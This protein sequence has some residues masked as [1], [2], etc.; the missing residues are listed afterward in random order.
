MVVVVVGLFAIGLTALGCFWVVRAVRL[1]AARRLT[2]WGMLVYLLLRA[3]LPAVI[4]SAALLVALP[5]FAP[6]DGGLRRSQKADLHNWGLAI[7]IYAEAHEGA[8]PP[9]L[10]TLFQQGFAHQ[11]FAHGPGFSFWPGQEVVYVQ[12]RAD[13]PDD[14]VMAYY[15]PAGKGGTYVLFK[16][17]IPDWAP[18]DEEGNLINPRSEE[19]IPTAG[20][21]QK[22]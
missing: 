15:W 5:Q 3:C 19:I 16:D 14:V 7:R 18:L 17:G 12:P 8:Y 4:V 9:D 21:P 22:P 1:L 2:R 11:G 10:G 13:A 6:A 20:E